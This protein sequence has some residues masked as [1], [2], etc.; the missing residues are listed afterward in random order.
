MNSSM[1]PNQAYDI[2]DPSTGKVYPFNQNRVWAFIPESMDKMIK[3]GRIIFPD[4]TSKRP[5]QKRFQS[6]LKNTYNPFSTLMSDK[7]GLNTEATRNIQEI[8][9][10]NIFEYSKPLSLL[11]T[12]IKQVGNKNDLIL[13]FFAGSSVTAH[14]VM[15]LN[16]DYDCYRKFIMI[17][18]PEPCNKKSEAFKAGYKTISDIGKERIRRVIKK[19]ESEK[20]EQNKKDKE[21]LF[22]NKGENNQK[23]DLGFKVFKLDSSNIKTWDTSIEDL[24]QNLLDSVNNVKSDRSAEDVLYEILLKYGL[25]LTVPI[26]EIKISGKKIYS[27]G[28]GALIICL[29]NDIQE[30]VI[31][32]II[33]LKKDLKPET[34]R[35]VF[36]DSSFKDDSMKMNAI[37]NLKQNGIEDIKS[38]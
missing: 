16:V 8:M 3:E 32:G 30:D 36:S 26:E 38:L 35:V 21:T 7:V 25:D 29:E 5:M 33:K 22:N 12:L 34:I 31:K 4:E 17:Q 6:E 11:S 37:E 10:G 13:D 20:E 14:A 19:I 9:G 18:L 24:E 28:Y 1:R 27:I 15:R 23:L 2:V